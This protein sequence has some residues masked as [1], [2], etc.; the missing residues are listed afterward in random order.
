MIERNRETRNRMLLSGTSW[1]LALLL[2]LA[3]LAAAA[4]DLDLV[5]VNRAGVVQLELNVLDE[6]SPDIVAETVGIKMTLRFMF[7]V[8]NSCL[9]PSSI[10]LRLP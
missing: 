8:R 7:K 5:C 4:N 1:C 2:V 9:R 10:S 3:L 6:E